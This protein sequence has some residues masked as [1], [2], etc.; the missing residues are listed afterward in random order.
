MQKKKGERM[1]K[2]EKERRCGGATKTHCEKF[3]KTT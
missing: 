1:E 3:S 2:E